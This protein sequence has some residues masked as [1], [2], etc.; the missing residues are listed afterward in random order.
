LLALIL[1]P[2]YVG[3]LSPSPARNDRISAPDVPAL[4]YVRSEE[5]AHHTEHVTKPKMAQRSS[6]LGRQPERRGFTVRKDL[7][8]VAA[9]FAGFS[10]ARA[11]DLTSAQSASPAKPKFEVASIKECKPADQHFPSTSSPGRLSLSCW[12]LSRLIADAYETFA[13]GKVDPGKLLV[14]MPLEGTPDWVNSARYT[15]DAKAESPQSGAMMR[16]PMMQALLED[17]FQVKVHRETREISGYLMTVDKG[18]LKLKHTQEGSCVH[19]DQTDLSQSPKALPCN[20]PR[21]TRNGPLMVFEIRGVSLDVF[22]RLLHP[23]GRPAFDRTGLT[24]AFDIRL[25]WEDDAANPPDANSGAASDPSPHASQIEAIRRQL[26]LRLDPG[27]GT[28][29]LLI[30]DHVE[31]PSAN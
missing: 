8:Y 17:R 26:G 29:E 1:P 3:V 5:C 27:K 4:V 2:G 24:G 25:E 30:I 14:A 16:G 10:M 19:I 20:A 6:R 12:S 21:V 15:I 22:A 11:Q 7:L 13:N 28:R 31:K 18:G 9:I 23:D